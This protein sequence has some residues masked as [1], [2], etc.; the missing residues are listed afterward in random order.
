M[1]REVLAPTEKS[2]GGT[3]PRGVS[4]GVYGVREGRGTET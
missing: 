3:V 1:S 2:E 4:E